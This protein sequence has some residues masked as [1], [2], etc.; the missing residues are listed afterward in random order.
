MHHHATH[1]YDDEKIE[2]RGRTIHNHLSGQIEEQIDQ[3]LLRGQT[4]SVPP[5][6][7]ANYLAGA[8][9]NLLTWWLNADMPYEPEQMDDIFQ[10]LTM[11]GVWAALG[12]NL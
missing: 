9:L 8:L 7:I 12:I 2:T 3:L 10:K 11:P 1:S 4:P 6:V 5:P